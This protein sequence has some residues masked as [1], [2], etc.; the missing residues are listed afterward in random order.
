[1]GSLVLPY[2]VGVHRARSALARGFWGLLVSKPEMV[3]ER[4][5]RCT[6]P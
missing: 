4:R 5:N 1:M 3:R 6:L 2:F